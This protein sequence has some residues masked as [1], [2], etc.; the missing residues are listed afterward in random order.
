VAACAIATAADAQQMTYDFESLAV[1]TAITNQ[2]KGVVISVVG[3]SCE[4][5]PTLYM[6]IGNPTGGTSSGT[7]ALGIDGGCPDFSPDYLRM[8]FDDTQSVVS[9]TLGDYAGT[10]TVRTYSD[11]G[12]INTRNIVIEGTGG[13]G[14]YRVVTI[15]IPTGIIRRIEVQETV[16]QWEW[17]DDLTFTLDDTAPTARID[18]PAAAACGCNSISVY[19]SA[20]DPDGTYARDRLEYCPAASNTWTL[21]GEATIPQEDGI[22]YNWN[23]SALSE[24][25]YYL[26]LTVENTAGLASSDTAMLWVSGDFDPVSY[27]LPAI[28]SGTACPDGTVFDSYCNGEYKVEYAPSGGTTYLPVDPAHPTYSG[29]MVNQTLATW[30]TTAV[31]DG[32]YTV[33]VTGTNTCN[34]SNALSRSVTVDNTPPVVLITSPAACTWVDGTTVQI[35]GTVTDTHLASWSVQYSGGT[36]HG[37]TTIANGIAPVSNGVLATWNVSAL[38]HCDYTVRVVA[39]DTA[40]RDCNPTGRNESEY[41]VSLSVGCAGDFNR[42]GAVSVQD[43]FDFLAA[44]FSGCP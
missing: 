32:V 25:F 12:L 35:V 24:G 39:H 29:Y 43:I 41:A 14:V 17:I 4:N 26:R 34:D 28:V 13:V 11:A 38:P 33:R 2:F 30:N 21:I 15:S 16:G 20:Y 19:G 3:Q 1:G 22:L 7:K 6:R 9:F 44:Y 5:D 42:T 23:T 8:V 18:T 40:V 31:A 10:Y 27:S 37:W 36:G